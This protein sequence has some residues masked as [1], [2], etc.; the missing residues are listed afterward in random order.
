VGGR[1]VE[2]VVEDLIQVRV[3]DACRPT[4]ALCDDGRIALLG[5]FVPSHDRAIDGLAQIDVRRGPLLDLSR[6]DEEAIDD[7][8]QAVD[9]EIGRLEALTNRLVGRLRDRALEPELHGGQGRSELVRGVRD[10]L[11]LRLDR[12]FEPVGHLVER[13]PE[14]LDLASAGHVA[15]AS[16]EVA[17][18]QSLRGGR[19][20]RERAGER[21]GQPEREQQPGRERGQPDRS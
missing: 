2:Q 9:L 10:E 11:A 18:P 19:Q 3:V 20:A 1:V 17:V 5:A 13:P 21:S 7:P 15:G 8:G 14:L 6:H 4:V 12:T 16:R